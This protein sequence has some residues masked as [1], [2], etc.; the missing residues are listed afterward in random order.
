MCTRRCSNEV[1]KDTVTV[2]LVSLKHAHLTRSEDK[3]YGRQTQMM[4]DTN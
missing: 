3:Q 1:R 2:T 4:M